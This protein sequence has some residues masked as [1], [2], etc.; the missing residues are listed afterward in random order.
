MS[1]RYRTLI[2]ERKVHNYA[3]RSS[4]A[5]RRGESL[6]SFAFPPRVK[7]LLH[8]RNWAAYT[9]YCSRMINGGTGRAQKKLE[10]R[11]TL[12]HIGSCFDNIPFFGNKI[13]KKRLTGAPRWYGNFRYSYETIRI[14]L[15]YHIARDRTRAGTNQRIR[16]TSGEGKAHR[17]A[18]TAFFP[19]IK[20]LV[21]NGN[22]S[23]TF[24]RWFD[25]NIGKETIFISVAASKE[26]NENIALH[27]PGRYYRAERKSGKDSLEHCMA[28]YVL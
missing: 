15:R 28:A 6:K 9:S 2:E 17:I 18:R 24:S 4:S 10:I 20:R 22:I 3:R 11:D 14:S 27:S 12:N 19:R 1:T 7:P 26:R 8:G 23:P 25:F 21:G 13:L 16:E 5:P